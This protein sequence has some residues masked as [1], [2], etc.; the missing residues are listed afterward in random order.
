M[1]QLPPGRFR[2]ALSRLSM[3][4]LLVAGHA[5]AGL[6]LVNLDLGLNQIQEPSIRGLASGGNA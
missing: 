6:F 1:E 2:E 4:L 5:A 3:P